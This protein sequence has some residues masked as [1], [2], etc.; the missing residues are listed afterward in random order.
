MDC[1]LISCTTHLV[2]IQRCS[3]FE[4]PNILRLCLLSRLRLGNDELRRF[5]LL[6]YIILSLGL[7]KGESNEEQHMYH[8]LLSVIIRSF[9][10]LR[11]LHPPGWF[12]CIDESSRRLFLLIFPRTSY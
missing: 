4:E 6:A 9:T 10:Y 2:D 5:V 11:K 3:R 12:E 7:P 1:D 8:L